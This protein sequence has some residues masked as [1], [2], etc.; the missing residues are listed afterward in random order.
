MYAKKSSLGLGIILLACSAWAMAPTLVRA[1]EGLAH[2]CGSSCSNGSCGNGSCGG[3]A[4]CGTHRLC[5]ICGRS[6]QELP[7]VANPAC[8]GYFPTQWQVWPCPPLQ[9]EPEKVMP[10]EVDG[11]QTSVKPAVYSKP[12]KVL[13]VQPAVRTLPAR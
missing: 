6:M 10:K 9:T 11:A 3:A 8:F 7:I 4:K 12:G 1:D 2:R 13:N 5:G